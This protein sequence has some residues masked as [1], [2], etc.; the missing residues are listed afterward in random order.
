MSQPQSSIFNET[1]TNYHHLEY[2]FKEGVYLPEIHAALKSALKKQTADVNIVIAFGSSACN[3]NQ[4]SDFVLANRTAIQKT[5]CLAEELRGAGRIGSGCCQRFAGNQ[6]ITV[7]FVNNP[8][9]DKRRRL[10]DLLNL[11]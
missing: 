4:L 2:I 11:I 1:S 8:G 6:I 3:T 5:S 10:L 7:G 9:R